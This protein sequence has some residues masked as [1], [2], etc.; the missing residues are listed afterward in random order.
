MLYE[1]LTPIKHDGYEIKVG[2]VHEF[3]DEQAKQLLEVGAIKSAHMPFAS[4]GN[5]AEISESG[6]VKWKS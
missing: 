5:H 3:N 1:V 4:S 6:A 2:E